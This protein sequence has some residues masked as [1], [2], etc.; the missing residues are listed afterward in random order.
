MREIYP[1]GFNS[2]VTPF[3]LGMLFVLGWCLVGAFRVLLELPKEDRKKLALS[4]LNPKTMVKNIRDWFFDCLFHVKPC[5][6]N[7]GVVVYI[8]VVGVIVC[9]VIV[10]CDVVFLAFGEQGVC[11]G[12]FV[13][14]GWALGVF[15]FPR[16]AGCVGRFFRLGCCLFSAAVPDAFGVGFF[17]TVVQ[18]GAAPVLR[19]YPCGIGFGGVFALREGYRSR[20]CGKGQY[21]L[22]EIH[23]PNIVFVAVAV[24]AS[25]E[26]CL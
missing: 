24:L 25:K 18:F 15:L 3:M 10:G 14:V 22:E 20:E 17:G 21:G 16:L 23:A 4:F 5:T 1:S 8:A 13:F 7:I 2:F 12:A 6:G 19:G 26:N 9:V 11:R